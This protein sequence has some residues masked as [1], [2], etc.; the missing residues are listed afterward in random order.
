MLTFPD[1]IA[2]RGRLAP[3]VPLTPLRTYRSLDQAVGSG[4]TV[5]VKHENHLPTNSFKYRNGL[6][7]MTAL[8]ADERARGVIATTL[9]NHGQGVAVAARMLGVKAKISCP[10]T[11]TPTRT[12]PFAAS[13]P[14]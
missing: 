1:I 10:S 13:A 9:G 6:A 8:S 14:N 11:T 4:I 12:R 2:A 7:A 5:F 3:F